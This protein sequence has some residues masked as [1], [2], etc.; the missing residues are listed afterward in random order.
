[1]YEFHL[2][3]CTNLSDNG[4]VHVSLLEL[5]KDVKYASKHSSPK[6]P[7]GYCTQFSQ[8]MLRTFKHSKANIL[9]KL[10]VRIT[11]S[12]VKVRNHFDSE[13]W[14]YVIYC[15][16]EYHSTCLLNSTRIIYETQSHKMSMPNLHG[17]RHL[18]CKIY[19]I[20]KACE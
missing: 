5:D 20:L 14:C 11:F 16:N 3:L 7:T 10:K 6:W 15:V 19:L 2:N 12:I 8:L 9:N 4:S 13:Y 1:M 18:K 17:D